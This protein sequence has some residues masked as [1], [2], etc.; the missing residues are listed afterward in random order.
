MSD[1][2]A[3]VPESLSGLWREQ[4]AR[5][6]ELLRQSP[7]LGSHITSQVLPFTLDLST[8]ELSADA[9]VA[10][11]ALEKTAARIAIES[12]VSLARAGDIDHLGGGL[13]LI[14]PLL[15][16]LGIT[17]YQGHHYAIEHGHT[18]IGYYSAL[19]ALGFLPRERVIEHFRRSLDM[20]GHV[21]WVPGGTPLGSGR[22]GVMVPVTTGWSLGLRSKF[23]TDALV[24]CHTGDAGWVSGQAMNGF[25]TASIQQ[26]PLVFVMH[27][28]HIQLSGTT[29]RIM[30][31][32]PRPIIASL[33]IEILEIASLH[34]RRELFRAYAHAYRA[35]QAGKPTLIYPT[36]FESTIAEFAEKYG[37]SDSAAHFA[38][39]HNASM[40]ARVKVPGS[41]MS[42]RDDH[43]ML[44]CLFYVNELPGG[45]AHHD[46]GMK[47]RDGAA[48]LANPMLALTAAETNA[49]ESLRRASPR[50][51]E[52][53]AR[54]AAGSPNLV[55]SASDVRDVALPGTD[56]Q[57][58]VRAGTEAAY[59]AVAK[60]FPEQCFFVS[61]DLNPS[62]KLGK[63]AALVPKTHQIE[64]SIQEQAA[65]LVNDGLAFVD[66]PQLNA[67]ATFA[68][69][70]EG[71]AREGFEFWRY[72]RNLNGVN[73]GL[74]VLM[75]LAHVGACTGRDH[76]SGWS[77][78][79]INLA[80]G[81]LPYLHRFYAPADARAGFI[82]ILDAAA[83][84]GG[85]IAAIPRDNL[86]VL[87]RQGSQDPLWQGTDAWTPTTVARKHSGAKSVI[88]AFGAPAF[89]ALSAAEKAT[90]QGVPTD[91]IV[92]NGLPLPEMFLSDV[93]STYSRV[94]T[95]ED[96][97]IGSPQAGVRGFAGLV[98]SRLRH[99]GTSL[100]HFGIVDPTVAPSE[101]YVKVWE[102]F[103]MTEAHLLQ[104]L[105]TK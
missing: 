51:V 58:S 62:T 20:A 104:V 28:N 54:P 98:A 47:G 49:V 100:H 92:I 90:Q 66:G 22:L 64:M 12:L 80:I 42:Y 1:L 4:D 91:A 40:Q 105:T 45:E 9:D 77:L 99:A 63:A 53:K 72:Q 17:D 26:A 68:A 101:H 57:V 75:H 50:L 8:S 33:G 19:A 86:P 34:D 38:A 36:G 13:E 2:H 84:Y 82:A 30:D 43:A 60:K 95:I 23:G 39:K 21:L 76:F 46:G 93:S 55:V 16:T 14:G 74:N 70:M 29:A 44:E 3:A 83:H 65:T 56:K 6:A 37:I 94:L 78:D 31:R 103:G 11:G 69:F 7:T 87:T 59:V 15:M 32:D 97:L 71:I 73:E 102:H 41:L 79:W 96:G 5:N 35:A 85:H 25:I 61:C 88:L 10:L 81:Y 24:V 18:S 67:F 27:R 52:Q 48:T 89:L